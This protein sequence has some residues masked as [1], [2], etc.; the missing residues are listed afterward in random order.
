MSRVSPCMELGVFFIVFSLFYI[1]FLLLLYGILSH[2]ECQEAYLIS[3]KNAFV[4]EV[5]SC[6]LEAP[7]FMVSCFFFWCYIEVYS[8]MAQFFYFEKHKQGQELLTWL[9]I[10]QIS[11]PMLTYRGMGWPQNKYSL[12]LAHNIIVIQ[13]TTMLLWKMQ[14]KCLFIY[15]LYSMIQILIKKIEF[16]IFGYR[17]WTHDLWVRR[18]ITYPLCCMDHLKLLSNSFYKFHIKFKTYWQIVDKWNFAKLLELA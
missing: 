3:L 2:Y 10:E 17:I 13:Q 7:S 11:W 18:P 12:Q 5:Y 4:G 6:L 8:R 16:M 9:Q 15:F 14:S 1:L